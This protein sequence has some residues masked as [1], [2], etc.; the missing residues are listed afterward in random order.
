L[1]SRSRWPL[2]EIL[3]RN[4][5]GARRPS[6]FDRSRYRYRACRRKLAPVIALLAPTIFALG[7]TIE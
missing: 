7:C 4:R 3:Q 2:A 5:R 6:V 1:A